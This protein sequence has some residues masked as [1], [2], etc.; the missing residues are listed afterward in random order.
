MILVQN[1]EHD[2]QRMATDQNQTI[3]THRQHRTDRT[4]APLWHEDQFVSGHVQTAIQYW[5]ETILTAHPQR[6]ELLG[7]IGGVRLSEFKDP[8]SAGIFEGSQSN[9]ADVPPIELPKHV[10]TSHE[11]WVNPELES[12][13]QKGSL[14]PWSTVADTKIKPRPRIC[15]PLRVVPNKPRLIWDAR[16]LIFLYKHSPFQM[17]GVG[18]VAQCSWKR[19]Q[20]VTLGHKSGFHNI[21]LAPES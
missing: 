15:L 14:A 11:G 5:K 18:K 6:D 2:K 13:E 4:Q 3:A 7:Y 16:Y 12:L 9:G 21:S 17:D 20:Q 10:P 1:T 8:V 19:A